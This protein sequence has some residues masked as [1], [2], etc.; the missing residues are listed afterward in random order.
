MTQFIRPDALNVRFDQLR[1]HLYPTAPWL[2]TQAAQR[3][4]APRPILRL[5]QSMAQNK[6]KTNSF[7]EHMPFAAS[8]PGVASLVNRF[9]SNPAVFQPVA[10][11][12]QAQVAQPMNRIPPMQPVRT[13]PVLARGVLQRST[14]VNPEELRAMARFRNNPPASY[15]VQ[16]VVQAHNFPSM[17]AFRKVR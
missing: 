15:G 7:R 11:Q 8:V 12:T 17:L 13:A 10:F 9:G 6:W 16:T 5:P 4:D 14:I 2:I 1:S 3:Q